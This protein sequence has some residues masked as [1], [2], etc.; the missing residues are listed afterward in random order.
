MRYIILYLLLAGVKVNA[1]ET[2][3]EILD[4]LA[5]KLIQQYKSDAKELIVLQT[6]K[7]IYRA[8]SNI[9]FRAYSVSSNGSPVSVKNKIIYA[10]LVNKKDSVMDRVLLNEDSLQFHG[11]I[12]IPD[13]AEEGYYQLRAWTKSIMQQSP[14]D[15]FIS[16]VYIVNSSRDNAASE[17]FHEQKTD[18]EPIIKFYPEGN[19]LINGIT[20]AVVY[21]ATDKFGNPAKISAVVKDNNGKEVTNFSGTGI[22]KFFFEPYSKDKT[23]N[24]YVKRENAED[25]V[26]PLPAIRTGAYQLSLQQRTAGQLVFRVALGDSV[27]NKKAP[28]FLLGVSAG[29][30]CFASA[31]AGMYVVNVPVESLPHGLADFYLFDDKK[32]V[33]SKRSVFIE[34]NSPAINIITDRKDYLPRQKANVSISITGNDG[35]PVKA[36]LSVSV[37]DNN[38]VTPQ[39]TLHASDIFLLRRNGAGLFTNELLPVNADWD[40]FAVTL[41]GNGHFLKN[42]P[43][44]SIEKNFYWDGLEVRGRI[45]DKQNNGLANELVT[46]MPDQPGTPV[47]DST[48]NAGIFSFRDLVFFGKQRF[49]VMVPAIYNKQQKYD[50]LPE[51][52]PYPVIQ[53]ASLFRYSKGSSLLQPLSAFK[54]QQGDSCISADARPG[55]Q[56]LALENTGEKKKADVPR[57]G[58]TAHRITA[59]KLDQLGLSNTVDAV[60]MLPGVIM[61]NNRLTIR[62]GLQSLSGSLSD[63]EPLLI[64]DGVQ[65]NAGSV[66]DYLN[67]ISPSNI[68]YI[69]VLIGP[70]AALYGTRGGNG[71]IVV[72]TTNQIREKKGYEGKEKQ[73]IIASGYYKAQ[74][75]FAPPYENDLVRDAGFTDNR[76]TIYWNG[77]LITDAAGKANFSFYTADLKNDYTLTVQGITD[78]GE[79]IFKT[80]NVKRR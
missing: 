47:H 26:Y 56:R 9:W 63:V 58:L 25:L 48:D 75:F 38:M 24:V 19:N 16:P 40:M 50:I 79:M 74:P 78:K 7:T 54:K 8:G 45:S 13:N 20:C 4:Q 30:I 52:N 57:K 32:E 60:K 23:Y 41:N 15:I 1:Q 37:T 27:Y 71:A 12:Q 35:K 34:G 28:S 10:E 76:A 64:V 51:K 36:V 29:K 68:E 11:S 5:A 80:Y 49:F 53:A 65:T 66:V 70:E 3:P 33:V 67:S 73:T 14:A 42:N 62:G 6:D 43:S 31:G 39:E 17:I 21:T 72:K 55:L 61:I 18:D 2:A 69:D 22:G 59:E 46:L 44:I 77:Q